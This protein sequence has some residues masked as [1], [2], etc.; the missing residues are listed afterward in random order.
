MNNYIIGDP[1]G[2]TY[3]MQSNLEFVLQREYQPELE[4]S[5]SDVY[6]EL[7]AEI[8]TK[9]RITNCKTVLDYHY[10]QYRYIISSYLKPRAF[11]TEK[12]QS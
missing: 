5:N 10:R 11:Q 4:D 7:S 6:K 12:Q 3:T 9:V 8:T 1:V 2:Y